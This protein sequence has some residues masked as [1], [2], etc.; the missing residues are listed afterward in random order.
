MS[1]HLKVHSRWCIKVVLKKLAKQVCFHTVVGFLLNL[2][3]VESFD[4][5]DS[6]QTQKQKLEQGN[7]GMPKTPV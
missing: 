3:G 1:V 2:P 6:R 4:K 5:I 7:N